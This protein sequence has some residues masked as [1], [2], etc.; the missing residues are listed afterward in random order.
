MNIKYELKPVTD[1][2]EDLNRFE[3]A[4]LYRCIFNDHITVHTF[5]FNDNYSR[6]VPPNGEFHFA[7][8]KYDGGWNRIFL[9]SHLGAEGFTNRVIYEL[10]KAGIVKCADMTKQTICA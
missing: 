6:S 1:A 2:I 4:I 7:I 3:K 8:E 10:L 5:G 9:I